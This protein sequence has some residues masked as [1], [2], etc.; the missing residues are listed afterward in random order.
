MRR[1]SV[2]RQQPTEHAD[3]V[4]SALCAA[5]ADQQCHAVA[6]LLGRH[7]QL[8]RGLHPDRVGLLHLCAEWNA[9]R[10]IEHV[11]DLGLP[12]GVGGLLDAKTR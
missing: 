3:E 5:V 6:A 11:R 8:A 9:T 7:P 10:V 2:T 4:A 12:G 1:L